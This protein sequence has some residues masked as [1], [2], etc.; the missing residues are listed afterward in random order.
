MTALLE[1]GKSQ[2]NGYVGTRSASPEISKRGSVG[3]FFA[4]IMMVLGGALWAFQGLAGIVHGSFY[5]QPAHYFI[6]TSMSTWGWVHLA[7]G[8]VVALAGIGVIAGALWARTI[9]IV[10]AGLSMVVNF[11]FI[12]VYPLWALTIIAVDMWV[13]WALVVHGREKV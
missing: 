2:G 3:A 8:I 12:P 5:V 1:Q 7:L 11:L 4:G 6:T 9:G 13:I 10:L